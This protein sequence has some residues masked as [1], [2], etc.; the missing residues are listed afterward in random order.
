MPAYAGTSFTNIIYT[1]SATFPSS[2]IPFFCINM[3][4]LAKLGKKDKEY[5]D[6]A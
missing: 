3:C 6:I 4:Y 5:G 2:K 1:K